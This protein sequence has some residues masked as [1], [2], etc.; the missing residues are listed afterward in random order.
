MYAKPLKTSIPHTVFSFINHLGP[1]ECLFL[2]QASLK[3]THT[4]THTASFSKHSHTHTHTHTHSLA[5]TRYPENKKNAK[6]NNTAIS[7]T[8]NP[9]PPHPP[10]LP[11]QPSVPPPHLPL[12]L[13]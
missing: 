4:H 6:Q 9:P 5:H 8:P 1:L 12:T 11:D 3:H 2:W 7:K 10:A 13:V